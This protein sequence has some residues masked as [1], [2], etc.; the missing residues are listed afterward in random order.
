M[1]TTIKIPP[2]HAVIA[3]GT[4]FFRVALLADGISVALGDK[5][6]QSIRYM[7]DPFLELELVLEHEKD[8]KIV[9]QVIDKTG[10]ALVDPNPIEIPLKHR[11]A[12]SMKDLVI[13]QLQRFLSVSRDKD[14]YESLEESM[15]FD[16]PDSDIDDIISQAEERFR[17][18]LQPVKPLNPVPK[19]GK[20]PKTR[21]DQSGDDGEDE[22]PTP[23][24]KPPS[25]DPDPDSGD[26]S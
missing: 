2:R 10:Y 5:P 18:G 7:G 1:Q 11:Q 6:R 3:R 13:E 24:T 19:P 16:P 12:Q 9:H 15:D 20:R 26:V 22:V 14:E 25:D 23:S 17:Q 21:Q 4:G 8:V